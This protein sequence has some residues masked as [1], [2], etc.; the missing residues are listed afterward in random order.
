MDK[1]LLFKPRLPEDTVDVPGVGVLRVR[2]LN[3]LEA[4]HVQAAKGPEETE[5]RILALGMVDPKLTEDEVRQW[6]RASAAGEIEPVSTRIAQLSGMVAESPKRAYQD[7]EA[8]PGS[9]FRLLPGS[10]AG[11]DGG[12]PA[13]G[14][15]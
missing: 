3:R 5:R 2:G 12:S 4:M 6:Q 15:E 8:D 11:D 9:E 7:F 14:S 13:D 1:S 10:E